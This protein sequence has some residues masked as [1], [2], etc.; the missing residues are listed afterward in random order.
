MLDN[1]S[2][3]SCSTK[4]I[5]PILILSFNLITCFVLAFSTNGLCVFLSNTFEINQG[6]FVCLIR[7]VNVSTPK[8]FFF[9]LP[10]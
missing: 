1:V 2:I 8:S 6:K 5:K 3:H 9:C 7:L 10:K 4:P